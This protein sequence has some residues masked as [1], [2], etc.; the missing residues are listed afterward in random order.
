[1]IPHYESYPIKTIMLFVFEPTLFFISLFFGRIWVAK[2][3]RH[4]T[5]FCVSIVESRTCSKQAGNDKTEEQQEVDG[6]P[7][8]RRV[9]L[10]KRPQADYLKGTPKTLSLKVGATFEIMTSFRK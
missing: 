2:V 4:V 7:E 5:S 8:P 1:M 9:S 3:Y 6:S 10:K